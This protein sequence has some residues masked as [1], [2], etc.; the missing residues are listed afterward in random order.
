M[1]SDRLRGNETLLDSKGPLLVIETLGAQGLR[2]AA[3]TRGG[4][5]TWKNLPAFRVDNFRDS[6]GAGDWCTAGIINALGTLGP[7]A[8]AEIA[9][10]GL[11][12][13]L[14]SGQAMASWTC[15]YDGPRGGMYACTKAEF[16]QAIRDIVKGKTRPSQRQPALASR[17][18]TGL[19]WCACCLTRT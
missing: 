14:R 8:L 4:R 3:R 1:A 7:R 16:E 18:K 9:H 5:R 19:V 15:R 13:A 17:A 6:G 2:F 11:E 12:G 10:A